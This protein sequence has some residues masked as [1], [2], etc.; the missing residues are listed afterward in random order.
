MNVIFCLN[1]NS[2]F[3]AAKVQTYYITAIEKRLITLPKC[4][5]ITLPEKTGLPRQ[6]YELLLQG[7]C[8]AGVRRLT[9]QGS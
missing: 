1:D 8:Q 6:R 2:R 7:I 5:N 3:S 4:C 9:V